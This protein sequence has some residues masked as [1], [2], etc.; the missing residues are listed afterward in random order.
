MQLAPEE[1]RGKIFTEERGNTTAAGAEVPLGL[2]GGKVH[3]DDEI[4]GKINREYELKLSG[5][6]KSSD[7]TTDN[8]LV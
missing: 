2:T 5:W 1:R 6:K 4:A 3:V 8:V 7:V